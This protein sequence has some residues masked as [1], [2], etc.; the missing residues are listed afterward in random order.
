MTGPITQTKQP[1][2]LLPQTTPLPRLPHSPT[3]PLTYSGRP[4]PTPHAGPTA[5]PT[6]NPD[7][8][9]PP[10][11]PIQP[12]TPSCPAHSTQAHNF[13]DPPSSPAQQPTTS[14]APHSG[15]PPP[16]RTM[17]TRAMDDISKPKHHFNLH[18]TTIV[19][20]P[21]SPQVA[22][23]PPEWL[24][25][26]TNEFSALIKNETWEL[27]PHQPDMNII[28]CMWIFKHK[29]RSDGSLERYKARLVCDGRSQQVGIDCGD[30][31][32]PVVKPATIHLILTLALSRSWA[33]NQLDVTYAFLHGNLEE[34]VYMHQP[35]G[36]RDS[37][38]PGHVCKLKK[39]LYGLK[40]APRAWYQRF[41]DFVLLQGFKQSK[42]ENS[43]FI[44][45]HG[46]DTAY[47][48]LYVDDI[49]LTT[50]S[51]TL[52]RRIMNSLSGEFA[53]KD[54][55]PLSHFLGISVTRTGDNMFLSHHSYAK[56]IIRRAAM[57]SCKPVATPVDTGSKL[58]AN[59]SAPFH[60][61]TTY[62]SLAGAL[63]YLTFTRP[64][65][66][67]AVQQICMHMHSPSN[68]H[69]HA[70]KRIIRYI[71]GTTDYGL[72]LNPA[73]TIS[74]RAYTDADWAGCPDTRRSTSGYCV[75]LGDNLLS[76]SSKRQPSVSR[77]SAEAEYRGVANVVSEICW[78]R[79]LLLELNQLLLKATSFTV[80]MSAQFIYRVTVF[81]ISGPNI[82]N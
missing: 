27:V 46:Q 20:I 37:Q 40:Q 59:S 51:D 19:P 80:T 21:K 35:M 42:S 6:F 16:T 54:L 24:T 36:F 67:Y 65:I 2:P 49:I 8:L 7:P 12:T 23:S 69:W 70:L 5:G 34:T 44:Y 57:D 52:H 26:M 4:R 62:R 25:A 10:A 63:Q 78:L 43:L 68:D 73:P 45:H 77:S 11:S 33:I 17:R 82:L 29:F 9:A 3:Q 41:T 47:L 15:S 13:P 50:F 81:G 58:G 55:G 38:F 66:S 60:D 32:S 56:D 1:N 79:N 28:R 61:P 22:L 48:L 30:T 53:M 14:T 74:L 18:T 75:Y 71:Q 72:Y 64:D 39:S 76:W 31:F